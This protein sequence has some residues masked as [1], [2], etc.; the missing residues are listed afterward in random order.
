MQPN[1]SLPIL[2]APSVP[3]RFF[4][5]HSPAALVQPSKS[6][7][8][9][10]EVE[11]MKPI[12]ALPNEEWR[13]KDVDV[14]PKEMSS[15]DVA[16]SM[17]YVVPQISSVESLS[18]IK[19]RSNNDTEHN[20][21]NNAKENRKKKKSSQ[22]VNGSQSKGK[23]TE[24]SIKEFFTNSC[25]SNAIDGTQNL[26]TDRCASAT[27]EDDRSGNKLVPPL[28]LKK[29]LHTGNDKKQKHC[30][31][32]HVLSRIFEAANKYIKYI[33]VFKTKSIKYSKQRA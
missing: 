28:K 10:G 27:K 3:T 16:S 33:C 6:T 13:Q 11:S 12:G 22:E 21:K 20:E 18:A 29:V 23:C 4:R 25:G 14:N 2:P 17:S 26:C 32:C 30:I 8:D 15:K 9:V 31:I 19:R 7:V 5:K 24:G 1:R